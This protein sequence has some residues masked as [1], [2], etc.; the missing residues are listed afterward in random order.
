GLWNGTVLCFHNSDAPERELPPISPVLAEGLHHCLVKALNIDLDVYTAAAEA[1]WSSGV[2]KV[3]TPYLIPDCTQAEY[4]KLFTY[5]LEKQILISP[6]YNTPSILPACYSRGE[7]APL[8][9]LLQKA[10]GDADD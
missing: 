5:L 3:S 10:L 2:W 9:N 1:A 4:S 8:K 6:Y 7:I